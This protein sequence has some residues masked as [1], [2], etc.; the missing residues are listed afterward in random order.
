[1]NAPMD[2]DVTGSRSVAAPGAPSAGQ[3]DDLIFDV[4]AGHEAIATAPKVSVKKQ[5]AVKPDDDLSFALDIPGIEKFTSAPPAA[6]EKPPMEINFDEISLELDKPAA[7][8]PAAPPAADGKDA[9]WH[10]VATKLDLASAYKE[11][12]D[13][14]GAREILEEVVRDGDE[15]QRAAANALMQ[16]LG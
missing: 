15:Q 10:D 11:M 8:A 14:A 1:M 9:Q 7:A 3:L 12:G 5:E 2:F 16:K 4:T 6:P 13:A